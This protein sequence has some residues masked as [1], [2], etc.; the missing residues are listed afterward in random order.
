MNIDWTQ[1]A[2]WQNFFNL[3]DVIIV[4]LLIYQLLKIIRN[5]KAINILNG[6][7]VF[8]LFKIISA[9]FRLET[10]DWIM[11]N[12][13][14]WSVVGAIIIFQPE[15]RRGLE[16]LGQRFFTTKKTTSYNNPTEK[17]IQELILACNYM[18]KRRI[19]ALI[20]LEKN[21]SLEDIVKTGTALDA[22][23]SSQLLIN[24]FIP[25]TPLHDGA[26]VIQELKIAAAACYLPLSE[27]ST[28]PKELGT[29][30][31]AAVGLSENTDAVTLVVSEETGHISITYRGKIFRD[32]DEDELRTILTEN[33]LTEENATENFLVNLLDKTLRGD[34]K[35]E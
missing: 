15:I 17:M 30:H 31:R 25:N 14:R 18:A 7:F 29:R 24:I 9:L 23:I 32:L 2:T 1:I 27:D 26:V 8:L 21:Q 11:N 12:I 34:E 20:C 16:H 33:F 3:I 5:T 4:W 13:I 19:G 10:I 28:I 6:V 22:D 35:N